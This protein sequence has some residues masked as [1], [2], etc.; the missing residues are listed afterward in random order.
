MATRIILEMI[1]YVGLLFV[2]LALLAGAAWGLWV[3]F[4]AWQL[5]DW[6]PLTIIGTS[7]FWSSTG[8]LL[9]L[10]SQAKKT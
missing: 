6:A 7:I 4:L 9:W 3:M 2:L 8:G 1:L 5:Y 10:R